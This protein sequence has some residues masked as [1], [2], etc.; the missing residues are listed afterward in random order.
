[1]GMVSIMSNCGSLAYGVVSAAINSRP[2]DSRLEFQSSLG[3]PPVLI[4]L[5]LAKIIDGLRRRFAWYGFRSIELGPFVRIKDNTIS[6]D[7][8]IRGNM[9][10]RVEVDQHSGVV[11]RWFLPKGMRDLRLSEAQLGP[12]LLP[13]SGAFPSLSRSVHDQPHHP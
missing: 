9:V 10:G 2:L 1:M 3:Q 5:D 12:G 11:T 13:I 8:F 7:L 6:I 4:G